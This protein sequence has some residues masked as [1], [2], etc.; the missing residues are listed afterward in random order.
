MLSCYSIQQTKQSSQ[1]VSVALLPMTVVAPLSTWAIGALAHDRETATSGLLVSCADLGAMSATFLIKSIVRRERPYTT[2]P[3]CIQSAELHDRFS[4]PSGHATATA[5]F[6]TLLS[7]RYPKW[8]V[9][10]PCTAYWLYTCYARLNLGVHYPS[11]VLVGSVVGLA[12]GWLV[13]QLSDAL[14]K[15][16]PHLLPQELPSRRSFVIPISIPL[17]L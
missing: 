12:S 9:I 16:V 17:G 3:D 11:D 8:Y 4:F 15:K 10:A 13:Y 5:S 7:L 14:L 6:A 2:Y 1:I